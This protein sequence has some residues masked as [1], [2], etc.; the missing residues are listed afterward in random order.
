LSWIQQNLRRNLTLPVVARHAAM[1]C[2]TFS[3]RFREHV[4]TTPAVWIA[5]ARVREAQ[6]LLETTSLSVEAV[7]EK[8]GF[9]SAPVL[10]ERF[11]TIVG[12]GPMAYR[13]AFRA[14]QSPNA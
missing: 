12:A 2:R 3:R 8:A 13:R 4:G 7:A 9:G 1:S 10:R 5:T 11:R 14:S 6:R